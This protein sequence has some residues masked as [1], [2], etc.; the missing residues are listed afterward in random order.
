MRTSALIVAAAFAM[1]GCAQTGVLGPTHSGSADPLVPGAKYVNMGSSF[2]AGAGTGSIAS[3]SPARCYQ[4]SVNYAR[5]LAARLNLALTDV[6]CGGATSAHLIGPWNELPPQ[7]EAVTGDTKLVTITVGGNDLAYAGNLVAAS[8]EP[9]EIIH[10]PQ[11]AVP[12]PAPHPVVEADY[13]SL[14]R[15]LRQ[16]TQE[17]KERAPRAWVVFIQ[18]VTLVPEVQCPNSRLSEAEAAQLRATGVRLAQITRRVAEAS[19]ADVLAMDVASRRHTTCDS[20]P[21]SL[22]LP[23]DY[24]EAQGAP[25]HPNRRG[26]EAIA[27]R[28]ERLLR[29]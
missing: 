27:E 2:A 9:G 8:C 5:L 11:M 23:R 21:W 15:N 6:S 13:Q 4:S 24:N 19:G 28:L 18:Y 17:L 12:C 20:E 1:E 10:V 22:G 7:I 29:R 16:L 14:E 25:W 26:M 3:G